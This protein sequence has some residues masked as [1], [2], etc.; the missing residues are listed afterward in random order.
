MEPGLIW[1]LP[2]SL[3]DELSAF[4]GVFFV[5]GYVR[6][7]L[8]LSG[9]SPHC[10][11]ELKDLRGDQDILV[12]SISLERLCE[13]L[14]RYGRAEVVG[15][16]FSVVR[17]RC[18]G[19]TYDFSVPSRRSSS[20]STPVPDMPIERDLMDRD[21]TINAIAYDIKEGVF[22][23]PTNGLRDIERGLIRQTSSRAFSVDALRTLR[24]CRLKAMLK[25]EIEPQTLETA[26]QNTD[27]LSQI[28]PER[29]GEEFAKI[30]LLSKPSI[31]LRCLSEIGSIAVLLPQLDECQGVTQPGGMHAHDVFDHI[32]LTVDNAPRDALVRFAALFHDI[33]KPRHRFIGDDGRARFYGHQSTSAGVA[34]RWLEKFAFSHRFASSVAKLVQNHM[35]T[36]PET[37]KGVRRFIRRIGEELLEPLFQLRFADTKSQGL[38]GD[39]EA[40]LEFY[41]RVRKVLAQ[42]P[43]L[44]TRDLAVNGN[45]VMSVLGIPPSPAVGQVLEKLLAMVVD[46][47]SLNRRDVLIRLIPE[48][49]EE[50]K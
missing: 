42:K 14:R 21:F 44:T 47:P 38:G 3:F 45:D 25:F 29:I 48:V 12:T 27:R 8:I 20:G 15:R 39:I 43:P 40:E 41:E 31:A 13:I 9:R 46:D 17:F 4:G 2:R 28:A 5:G 36:H 19:R 18:G 50:V 22:V 23:D 32:L 1:T 30:I 26:K 34:K 11:S 16:N 24:A 33:T 37:D 6:N 10:P 7:E 49:A 35:F